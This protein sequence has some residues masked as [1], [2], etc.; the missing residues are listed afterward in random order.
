MNNI[1][2]THS[3]D[4]DIE[5]SEDENTDDLRGD[6]AYCNEITVGFKMA[7][8]SGIRVKM[9]MYGEIVEWE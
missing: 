5:L 7:R 8:Y 3:S 9:D 4:S 2:F 1:L 6:E